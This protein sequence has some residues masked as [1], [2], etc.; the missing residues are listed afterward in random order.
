MIK[1]FYVSAW[2]L[3]AAAVLISV[4]TGAFNPL[5]MVVFSLVAVGLVYG[6]AM[7]SVI[8]NTRDAPSRGF[9]TK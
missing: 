7:W 3:L 8:V 6:F 5:A 2:F 9:I 1:K 4:F